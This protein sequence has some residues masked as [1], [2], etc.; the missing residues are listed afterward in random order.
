MRNILGQS[1]I[2]IKAKATSMQ[3]VIN[4]ELKSFGLDLF[5]VIQFMQIVLYQ[6]WETE[7][8]TGEDEALNRSHPRE[9]LSL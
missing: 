5:Q 9:E 4:C 2:R 1:A 3:I 6:Q 7:A 8:K